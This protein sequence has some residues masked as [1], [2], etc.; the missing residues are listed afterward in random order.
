MPRS[1]KMDP[2]KRAEVRAREA[3]YQAMWQACERAA[4]KDEYQQS[5]VPVRLVILREA[6][7]V[8]MEKRYAFCSCPRI[9][10]RSLATVEC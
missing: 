1:D 6:L 5:S 3:E 8:L 10:S 9:P 4:R 2:F 7:T